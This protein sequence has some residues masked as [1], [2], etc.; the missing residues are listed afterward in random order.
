MK[1]N[2]DIDIF[3]LNIIIEMT[4]SQPISEKKTFTQLVLIK[5]KDS[6]TYIL[7]K[8]KYKTQTEKV[9]VLFFGNSD[10]NYRAF[11]SILENLKNKNVKFRYLKDESDFPFIKSIYRSFP[12]IWDLLRKYKM[13]DKYHRN[14]IKESFL[15]YLF[16]YGKY[17]TAK[18]AIHNYQPRILVLAND[19]SP[20]NRCFLK[21]ATEYNIK[22]VYV[23]H[24]S[25]SNKFPMLYF[26]YSFLDGEESFEKYSKKSKKGSKILL[27]GAS[28]YDR[29]YQ[30]TI[31]NKNKIGIAVNEYDDFEIVSK[32]CEKLI[33]S[34]FNNIIVRPHPSMGQWNKKWFIL[35]NIEF[36]DASLTPPNDYLS[37]LILNISN[38]SSIHLDASIIKIPTV[39]YQLSKKTIWDQYQYIDKK[40]VKQANNFSELI[41]YI[42]NPQKIIPETS[43]VQYFVASAYSEYEG[44]VGKF[45][46]DYIEI[47]LSGNNQAE[48]KIEEQYNIK[49]FNF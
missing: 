22:T 30:T 18:E 28:R 44:K 32:L 45:I 16:I 15:S 5:I 12:Y 37:E 1:K 26:D 39:Q 13:S 29:F 47:I 2:V 8:K 27:S 25:V 21:I 33:D 42:H 43:V 40:L 6:I 41:E 11:E 19:H 3:D 35:H 34:G 48:R 10:N 20:M 4:H 36:S 24:A 23:Q 17:L 31:C 49:T 9:D 38:I 7:N 14:L 46:A